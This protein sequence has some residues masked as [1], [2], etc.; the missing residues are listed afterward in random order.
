MIEAPLD[1]RL[2][3]GRRCTLMD[4]DTIPGRNQEKGTQAIPRPTVE[5]VTARAL[6]ESDTLAEATPKVLQAI[7]EALGWEHGALWNVDSDANVLRCVQT[8]HLPSVTFPEFESVSRATLFKRGIGLPGRV[9]SS[10]QPAWIQDVVND[11]NFPRA[12]MAA[13][14]GLHAAFGFPI[15]LGTRVL[16]VMEFFSSEIRRPDQPLLQMLMTVGSQLGQFMERKRAQEEHA[17]RLTRLVDELDAARRRAEEAMEA[18]GQFLAN[19]SHEIRTPLNAVIG[20]T[21]LALG[22]RPSP[23]IRSY[24]QPVM[25]SAEAL[26]AI[27]NDILDFSKIEA[28]RMDLDRTSFGLRETVEET[29]HVLAPRAQAKGLELAAD[30]RR[31]V[32]D[33]L[34]GD[35]GRLRQVIL[36]LVGNAIKFTDRGEIILRVTPELVDADRAQLHFSV[37]DTG[38]GIPADM[39]GRIFE[40]FRQADSSITRTHGGTGLGLAIASRLVELM[41]GQLTVESQVGRGSTFHFTPRFDRQAAGS[42]D[43]WLTPPINLRG[44]RVLVADDKI[45]TR[46]IV[47]GMVTSWSMRPTTVASGTAA[48][49][50]L[51]LA[52]RIG[53]PFPIVIAGAQM[54]GLS[55][56]AL[57]RRLARDKRLAG[58]QLIILTSMRGLPAALRARTPAVAGYVTTPVKHSDL[59]DALVMLVSRRQTGSPETRR[60]PMPARRRGRALRILIAEDNAVNRTLVTKILEKRGHTIV[61]VENG[62]AAVEGVVAAIGSRRPFDVVVMDIQMPIMDGLQATGAIRDREA[63]LGGRTPIVALTAHAMSGD[64]ERCLEAGM[65]AYLVKPLQPQQ[66]IETVESLAQAA[67]AAEPADP[68]RTKNVEPRSGPPPAPRTEE[69]VDEADAL[70]IAGGDPALMRELAQLFLNELPG[71]L[72]DLRKAAAA[73]DPEQIRIAAHALKGS[74][75]AVGGRGAADAS[76]RVEQLGR[77]GN[78]EAARAAL[79]DLEAALGQVAAHLRQGSGGHA[80][81]RDGSSRPRRSP[82]KRGAKAGRGARKRR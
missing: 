71:K 79:V 20:M 46:R 63:T 75:A 14:E 13:R 45:T 51:E 68:H 56:I 80:R 37:S 42:G 16:G 61:A 32:P 82:K 26:L 21:E 62:R 50:A 12:P 76:S 49:A 7:C 5:Y 48:V 59:L 36:N 70:N 23:E 67:P 60:I 1:G 38:I 10:G 19:M 41:G 9:W 3:D 69:A 47:E 17:A 65:T 40:A 55:G 72:S 78:L 15:L 74:A 53:S 30:I 52:R 34:V 57:G 31:D 73:G 6:A 24:L 4:A 43:R 66:L 44:L 33:A 81:P 64:R 11:A 28:R 35:A 54:A 39:H 25:R 8:W 2:H 27:I 29:V 77:S 22:A 18:R 58:T